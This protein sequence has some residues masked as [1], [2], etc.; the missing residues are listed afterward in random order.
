MELPADW[1][2]DQI[3]AFKLWWDSMLEG[4]TGA[5]RGTMFV[6]AGAKPIDTKEAALKDEY[7]EWLARDR[8]LRL[9]H[10]PHNRS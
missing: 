1:N 7:D 10:Q 3:K 9:R 5:R 8:V 2:P 4:N 6:P